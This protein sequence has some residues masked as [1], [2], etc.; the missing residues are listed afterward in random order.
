M[1]KTDKKINQNQQVNNM[2]KEMYEE[3]FYAFYNDRRKVY[4][5]NFVRGVFFGLGTFLSGTVVIAGVVWVLTQFVTVPVIG[6]FVQ[7]IL[8]TMR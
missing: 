6:D 8:D 7:Q 4:W 1:Q 2:R 3:F 5:M